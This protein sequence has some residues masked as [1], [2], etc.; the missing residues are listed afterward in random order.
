[1]TLSRRLTLGLFAASLLAI[2]GCNAPTT[3]GT[4]HIEDAWA[5]TTAPGATTGAG[6]MTLVNDGV[7]DRLV[8]ASS[9]AAEKVELHESAMDGMVMTMRPLGPVGI[10]AG[11]TVT[12]APN[13]KHLMFT[14]LKAPFIAGAT[15][16]VD[17]TFEIAGVR[18]VNLEVRDAAP[19]EHPH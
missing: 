6:Y 10:K 3:S 8:S 7:A 13:G 17:L 1:M 14:G 12:L 5:R 18:R 2:A 16:P 19:E 9:P 11:A 15:V 4:L